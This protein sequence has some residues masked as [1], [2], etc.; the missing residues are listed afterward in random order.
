MHGVEEAGE[1]KKPHPYSRLLGY[2]KPYWMIFVVAIICMALQAATETFFAALTKPM[3]DGTFGEKDLESVHW[4]LVLLVGVFLVRGIGFFGSN[5]GLGWVSSRIVMDLRLR[6]FEKLVV[7]PA[8]Y[9]DRIPAGKLISKLSFDV[10]Q[11]AAATSQG[12]IVLVRDT[13]SIFGLVGFMF[14]TQPKLSLIV[15]LTGPVLVV[16]MTSVNKRLRRLSRSLQD[17]MGEIT[18]AAGET[19][20]SSKVMKLYGAQKSELSRFEKAANRARIFG[21]KATVTDAALKPFVQ[22]V[23]VIAIVVASYFA[24][25]QTM[26]GNFTIGSFTSFFTA[27][28]LLLQPIKRLISVNRSLQQGIAAGESIFDLIDQEPEVDRGVSSSR[29][30]EGRIE[31]RDV[32][33]AYREDSDPV[34]RDLNF[35]VA[36][37]QTVALVG[38]SGGGKSTMVHLLS[39][40]YE[41]KSGSIILDG[42]DIRD[43]SLEDLRKNIA[44]VTQEVVLFN[45]TV[46]ANIAYGEL[47]GASEEEILEAAK[48]AN[49]ME[50]IQDLP[51]GLNTVIGDR[52]ALLSVGQRQRLTIARAFLKKAP[53]L[54][55]DEATSALDANSEFHV[56][57]AL[58][59]VRK[60]RTTFVIAHRLSTIESAD[61]IL[62][63]GEGE[64]VESGSHEELLAKGTVYQQL[65]RTQFARSGD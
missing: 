47:E 52:G 10:Q 24:V 35:T 32:T 44:M 15:I 42:E 29:K 12:V 45:D 37:G 46:R 27:M 59:R 39:R 23:A 30:V 50:F 57:E 20:F 41:L 13:L 60:G 1:M 53:L 54:I 38:S 48:A 6:M 40:L 11:V 22:L 26:E 34:L 21:L 18:H 36:P 8:S 64:I 56:Q 9:Y 3:M 43:F 4:T 2:V 25:G 55:L 31:F 28:G 49:A 61:R 19:I 33:F 51:D 16:M 5:V 62:V 14:Y 63:L 65:Y 58:D 17:S 7:I